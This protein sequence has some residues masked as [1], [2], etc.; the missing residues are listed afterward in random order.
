MATSITDAEYIK[1][2][3]IRYDALIT[4]KRR[5]QLAGFL[6][7]ML[8]GL[9]LIRN[10]KK[11]KKLADRA[12][13]IADEIHNRLKR[14]FF[15]REL[16]ML[17][18]YGNDGGVEVEDLALMQNRY[19]GRMRADIAGK[20]AEANIQLRR[21]QPRYTASFTKKSFKDFFQQQ[22]LA[23]ANGTTA[24]FNV[25]FAE[26]QAKEALALDRRM[27]VISLGRNLNSTAATLT[28]TAGE[29]LADVGHRYSDNLVQ[30]QMY[31]NNADNARYRYDSADLVARAGGSWEDYV[32]YNK[33]GERVRNQLANGTLGDKN[34]IYSSQ[35]QYKNTYTRNSYLSGTDVEF[36]RAWSNFNGE[37]LQTTNKLGFNA[38]RPTNETSALGYSQ[39]INDYAYKTKDETSNTAGNVGH[40]DTVRIGSHTYEGYGFGMVE[41]TVNM[42]DFGIGSADAKQVSCSAVSGISCNNT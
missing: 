34:K 21:S 33:I 16:Q 23:M 19:A 12:Q 36:G 25:A 37:D 10:F 40:A 17:K 28:K 15:P 3:G 7:A 13:A 30:A 39:L 31:L 27:G 1:A 5:R 41:I 22:A 14:V 35:D 24:G 42:D 8:N 29:A 4:A 2:E 20:F 11:Q 38:G 32:N 26:R 9:Q 6:I 18:E